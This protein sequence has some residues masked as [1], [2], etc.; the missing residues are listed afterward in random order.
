MNM[1][2]EAESR[3]TILFVGLETDIEAIDY[4]ILAQWTNENVSRYIALECARRGVRSLTI[5][6]PPKP[7]APTVERDVESYEVGDFKFRTREAADQVAGLIMSLPR[8]DTE[9]HWESTEKNSAH[10]LQGADESHVSVSTKRY[11]STDEHKR[12]AGQLQDHKRALSEWKQLDSERA[13]IEKGQRE[14]VNWAWDI[15][16]DARRLAG[17]LER[18]G[19]VLKH[20]IELAEGNERMGWVFF[21]KTEPELCEL[22]EEAHGDGPDHEPSTADDEEVEAIADEMRVRE[23][24]NSMEADDEEPA[25]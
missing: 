1:Q 25:F 18:A 12:M 24:R 10:P 21:R 9:Y 22:Y 17:R 14:V 15:I 11:M 2:D 5:D 6:V 4:Q 23:E 7:V 20:Y 8:W 13:D 16:N 19:N 3:A